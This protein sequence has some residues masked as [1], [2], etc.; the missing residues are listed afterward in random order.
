MSYLSTW[1]EDMMYS[2]TECDIQKPL[3]FC[4]FEYG[5]LFALTFHFMYIWVRQIYLIK[6]DNIMVMKLELLYIAIIYSDLSRYQEQEHYWIT[7]CIYHYYIQL[8]VEKNE[9]ISN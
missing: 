5:E 8:A 6:N 9:L 7:L 1:R 4:V 3:Y 2:C